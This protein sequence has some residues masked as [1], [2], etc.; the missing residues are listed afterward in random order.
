MNKSASLIVCFVILCGCTH[1]HGLDLT[2]LATGVEQP[3][4]GSRMA[5]MTMMVRE[6]GGHPVLHCR[7]QNPS[8]NAL[9][10][11]RS[12][13]PWNQPIYFIGAVV[14]STGRTFAIGPVGVLAYVV[15]EPQPFLI[16]PGGVVEGD[17][18]LRYLPKNP[19]VGPRSTSHQIEWRSAARCPVPRTPRSTLVYG[20][21]SSKRAQSGGRIKP[22]FLGITS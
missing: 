20:S 12:R 3:W 5:S 1:D 18:E 11:D 19:M 10:V 21:S 2:Q 4:P 9:A 8:S 22:M 6:S 16:A 17:F 7:L 14:T 15:G 13:L